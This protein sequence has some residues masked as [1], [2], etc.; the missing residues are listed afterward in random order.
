MSLLRRNSW[1]YLLRHPAQMLL[2]ILG[3]ALG[4]AVMVSID[5]AN[6]SA[7]RAFELSSETITGKATDQIVGGPNGLPSALY[8]Q[9]RVDLGL[10]LSAPVVE[11]NVGLPDRPGRSFRLLGVDAFAEGPFRPYLAVG[12]SAAN[13]GPLLTQPNTAIISFETAQTLAITTGDTL[14]IRVAGVR[15]PLR[16]VG[17]L[18]G[19]DELSRR[20]LADVLL[21]DI[22]TAQELVGR[23]DRIS[24][25]DLI[26]PAATR[27]AT[28]AQLRAIIPADADLTTPGARSATFSQ[29]TR[30]FEVNLQALS[31]L[32]L[33][34]GVFLIYN[35]M[36]FSVVQRRT[37][38]GTLRSLGVTRG[39]VFGLIISEAALVGALGAILGVALGIVLGR[40]LV[41]LVTQTINDLYFS[42]N[43]QAVD[44]ALWPL[45]KGLILGL[46]AT[47]LAACVPALEAT[48]AAPRT[49]LRRSSVE[50]RMRRL[51]PRTTASGVLLLLAGLGIL[52][53]PT[54]NL[55]VS[56]SALFAI[57]IGCALLTPAVTV[58]LMQLMRPVF[59]RA[60]GLLGRMAARDVVAAL[61]RTG[62]A[63]AALMV[64]VSVTVGAGTMIGS[65]RQTVVQWLDTSLQADIFISSPSLNAT[66]TDVPLDPAVVQRIV[67]TEGVTGVTTFVGL[68]VGSDAGPTNLLALQLANDPRNRQAL[69]FIGDS[70]AAWSR[71]ISGEG[72]WVS[73]PYAYRTGRGLGD[74]LTLQSERGPQTFPIVGVY[75]DYAS[76]V[77]TVTI[78]RATFDRFWNVPQ[79]SSM[80]VWAAP[81]ADI[82]ALVTRLQ[83][84]AGGTQDLLIQPNQAIRQAT[85]EVFDRT[86]AIT[87]VL[88]V[89]ATIVAFIGI[90]SALMALQLERARE[91]GV[92]RANGLTPG[93]LWA[94]VLSQTGLMG[95]TAGLLAL[96]VGMILAVVLVFVINKRSFGWTL[97]MQFDPGLLVQAL[98][99]SIV[100]ALLAGL[101]P[102]WRMARTSP[103]LAL[104]E[105]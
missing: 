52:Q 57:L 13:L 1:R 29:M 10:R 100:A 31:L 39:E 56:F 73:E 35:T 41:Q 67:T 59:G 40:G 16:I 101:Y 70:D 87:A 3:V 93:Q 83:T 77:G 62:V 60:F 53:I 82:D 88:Q 68:Q 78:N 18:E 42:V 69:T 36:T 11:A 44:L 23:P 15:Q 96:P 24:R 86:F 89:L 21:T 65:F 94:M 4:V 32:A 74:T 103:A 38:F 54:R 81:D 12:S 30:A 99:V 26:L 55:I 46:G 25:I 43:V 27:E 84:N 97:Q 72:V 90:L 7:L 49:V 20:G 75:Y 104:R 14:E 63:I 9:I 6:G 66:R 50:E 58:G 19:G 80:A 5:L 76:D 33:I 85:L 98:V 2:A 91:L 17:L 47:V 79:I 22:A 28:L 71:F 45:L 105:E 95:L 102:A 37:L 61:S 34:V 51:L 48:L 8:R 92:L 64:A